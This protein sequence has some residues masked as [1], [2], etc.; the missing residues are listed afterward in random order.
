MTDFR[1]RLFASSADV[2]YVG[3]GFLAR[4]LP[5]PEWTHEAHLATTTYLLV[6]HP[7]IDLD[8]EL[9]DLIRRYNESMGGVNSDTRA[10]T[11]RSPGCS[12]TACACSSAK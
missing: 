10:I 9:P 2:A 7:E 5:H 1:P 6:K 3:E 11:R 4:T 8:S 12:S